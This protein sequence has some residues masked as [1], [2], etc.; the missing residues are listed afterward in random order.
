MEEMLNHCGF[1]S[2][3]DMMRTHLTNDDLMDLLSELLGEHQD[4]AFEICE[5]IAHDK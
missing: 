5:E 1:D 3:F 2:A 4:V